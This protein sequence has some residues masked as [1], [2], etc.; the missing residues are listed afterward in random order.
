LGRARVLHVTRTLL[1]SDIIVKKDLGLIL[2]YI[3]HKRKDKVILGK[4]RSNDQKNS[5]WLIVS[6]SFSGWHDPIANIVSFI[7]YYQNMLLPAFK[8][9]KRFNNIVNNKYKNDNLKKRSK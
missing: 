1:T 3:N 5:L 9:H 2:H 6:S 8:I 4:E 7:I